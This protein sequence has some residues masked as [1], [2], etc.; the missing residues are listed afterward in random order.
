V[1]HEAYLAGTAEL[2]RCAGLRPKTIIGLD[3]VAFDIAT[4][5]RQMDSLKVVS[6]AW[7]MLLL[8][9]PVV[10][11]MKQHTTPGARFAQHFDEGAGTVERRE[12]PRMYRLRFRVV[13]QTRSGF[14]TGTGG[15][16]T[17]AE[18]QSLDGIARFERW[19]AKHRAFEGAQ[20]FT[21]RALGS[22]PGRITPADII[23]AV[24][25]IRVEYVQEFS[26]AAE[27]VSAASSLVVGVDP[28]ATIA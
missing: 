6:Q 13:W 16:A 14:G 17:T 25:E 2:A 15:T 27:V 24:G 11:Q 18:A 28:D 22:S 12:H 3:A 19:C 9:G 10:E 21:T 7:P 4:A 5:A 1:S 20:L 8:Y 23:E 26:D